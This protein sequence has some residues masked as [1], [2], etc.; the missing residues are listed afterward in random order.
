MAYK[1][2]ENTIT[3]VSDD[4]DMEPHRSPEESGQWSK[5]FEIDG[6]VD[7]TEGNA[8]LRD[9]IKVKLS[10][11]DQEI[12]S[13]ES[14]LKP[15]QALH[16]TLVRE[17]TQLET[18]LS[19]ITRRPVPDSTGSSTSSSKRAVRLSNSGS[20]KPRLIDYQTESFEW[21]SAVLSILKSTFK[22]PSFRLCQEGVVN[23][24]LD[25][26]DIVCV[27]PTGGGKSL[28]YQLPAI[29]GNRGLTIVISP[30]LA[31][32]WD[33]VRA[34][35]DLGVECV[36]LT[37]STSKEEQNEIYRRMESGSG[38]NG[39]EIRLCYV[40]P[41]KI[42]KSKRFISVLEKANT[43][44]RLKRIVIDE[45]HCCS[46]LG[47]DFRPDY[48][49]LSMLKT[50]FPRVPI[51][52]VTA[53]LSS[54]TMPDLLKIL[55]L[56]PICDGR[57]ANTSGTVFF[58]SPLYRP[59]LH[60]SVIS[61]PSSSKASV[62]AV[63]SWI[64]E[65]HTGES[66]IIYCLSKK[67]AE[68]VA[69]ALREWSKQSIKTGVYHAGL[70]DWQ[71][72][73]I[74]KDWRSGKVNVICATI[75]FGL[76]IDKG[77]VRYVIHHS[78]SKS[79]EGYYQETGRAGRD[80]KDSDCVLFYRGQD[81]SRLSS[82]VYQDADG[83]SKLQEMLR[84]AEDLRTCRKVAFAKYFSHSA[85]LSASAWDH[86]ETLGS[87]STSSAISVCGICDNCTREPDSIVTM[88]VTLDAWRV[89]KVLQ[90]VQ[91]EQGRLTIASL[92]DLVRGLGGGT[93]AVIAE[94]GKKRG[95]A[96]DK[97]RVDLDSVCGG[98]VELNKE[99]TESLLI[100]MLLNGYLSESYHPTAYAV[101][102]YIVA[103]SS[104][105]RLSRLTQSEVESG[106][107]ATK[108]ECTFPAPKTK[109]KKP[110][111]QKVSDEF[112]G[113]DD[114]RTTKKP[115][116]VKG[117]KAKAKI[118]KMP[119]SDR[120]ELEAIHDLDRWDDVSEDDELLD[121]EEGLWGERQADGWT[122]KPGVDGARALTV[123][124]SE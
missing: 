59:N 92:A 45:A 77:D 2:R 16:A 21:S 28:T 42:S 19:D 115:R 78:M 93:F 37:G 74:H 64:R 20:S 110:K 53:T 76:G 73:G 121:E 56:P 34:M 27:M 70:E 31:L 35:K 63:G 103:S 96:D 85:H 17:R 91:R 50:L 116:A 71:K 41:E 44:G 15:L 49:K 30:L 43:A 81:A 117:S 94:K 4:E 124:D 57:A 84:F 83:P 26:R 108:I 55:R 97:A 87:S 58:S 104:A 33:Q 22:L 67:D 101:N 100:H 95:A 66:G 32:I 18:Q 89:L 107:I 54:K 8:E 36:M 3:I 119:S 109:A 29:L 120:D 82:L 79:L 48:K 7:R 102:V 9:T 6:T 88:D 80:G 112:D 1:A 40:T 98:K 105:F 72:E 23:A 106:S 38:H 118:K 13:V 99:D 25:D 68:V 62:E 111:K 114:A 86:S 12:N 60:Y 69:E 61:K 46:Q 14:Q 65:H 75:A 11:L 10:K 24:A 39:R 51:Q 5:G 113:S 122:V 52:A 123:S 90:V 47:H